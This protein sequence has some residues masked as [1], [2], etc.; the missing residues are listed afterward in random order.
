MKASAL[1][2]E[3]SESMPDELHAGVGER[4]LGQPRHL[5]LAGLAPR[6][7]EVHHDRCAAELRHQGA[8]AR[9][10]DDGEL[11]D[12]LGQV[13]DTVDG[14]ERGEVATSA[15]PGGSS[16]RTTIAKATIATRTTEMTM[17]TLRGMGPW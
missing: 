13:R 11:G 10:V 5:D 2:R 15:L 16:S 4:R 14:E 7:P 17:T 9:R 1:S 12:R 8:E 3:S 6:G